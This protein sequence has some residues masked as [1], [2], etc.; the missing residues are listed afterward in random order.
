MTIAVGL[1]VAV[2]YWQ[3]KATRQSVSNSRKAELAEE[4]IVLSGQI[5]DAFKHM[6]NPID[7]VPKDKL[8]DRRYMFEKRYERVVESNDLF[9]KLRETQIRFDASV[10]SEKTKKHVSELFNYRTE[11]AIAIETL[12]DMSM[13]DG[14]RENR[15]ELRQARSVLYGTW[16]DRDELGQKISHQL[17]HLRFI[18]GPYANWSEQK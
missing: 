18:A 5:E 8:N 12:L 11:I 2:A 6:R 1:G 3:L 13:D 16:G 10:G 4:L 7:S 9:A 17:T 14:A 15:G